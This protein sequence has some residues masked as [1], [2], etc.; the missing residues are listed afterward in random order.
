MFRQA[1]TAPLF[2][3]IDWH[4][5]KRKLFDKYW[6][7]NCE[8]YSNRH[9]SCWITFHAKILFIVQN[10]WILFSWYKA[11]DLILW[12]SV[13]RLPISWPTKMSL[14]GYAE[15]NKTFWKME[16]SIFYNWQNLEEKVVLRKSEIFSLKVFL[17][18]KLQS[19]NFWIHLFQWRI[20]YDLLTFPFEVTSS[21]WQ[22]SYWL[23]S[24]KRMTSAVE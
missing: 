16:C 15:E 1:Y 9:N 17:R 12:P 4:L 22:F 13:D 10:I 5:T 21:D 3:I 7:C 24:L 20:W 11:N 14:D 2:K 8:I 18:K 23:S 19:Q 6:N